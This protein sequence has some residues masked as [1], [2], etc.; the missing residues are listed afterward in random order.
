[1]IASSMITMI[2]IDR[3]G[4]TLFRSFN[5]VLMMNLLTLNKKISSHRNLVI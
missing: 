4:T 5:T 3:V 1:M 2:P